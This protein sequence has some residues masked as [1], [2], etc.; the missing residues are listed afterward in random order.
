METTTP[1]SDGNFTKYLA[2]LLGGGIL[3]L[4]CLGASLGLFA[5]S[6]RLAAPPITKIEFLD[7]KLRFLRDHREIDPSLIV[8]GSSIAWR[9]FDGEPFAARLGQNRVLNGA[10]AYLKVHQTR[11]LT[12]FYMD[13]F[14]RLR[15]VVL[16]FGPTDFENCTS[17]QANLFDPE[18][19]S[20]YVFEHASPASFYMRYF[21]PAHYLLRASNYDERQ[22]PLL[23]DLFM[24][25][26]GSGPMQWTPEM[27]KG[28]R[29]GQQRLD[30][31]CI[32]SLLTLLEEIRARNIRPVVVF[33][34][35][36]PE[37]R[38]LYPESILQ[39]KQVVAQVTAEGGQ[40]GDVFDMINGNFQTSDFFDAIHL[41]WTAVQRFS[42][43]L[44]DL[45]LPLR[46]VTTSEPL[47]MEPQTSID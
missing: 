3:T 29:Y 10:T 42:K 4:A 23:G 44:A 43:Q 38:R 21:S 18:E 20:R 25:R 2:G 7:E 26:Y 19:G 1:A 31:A 34:P 17:T 41:Q 30:N 11:F 14:R 27:I 15:T 46:A 12:T 24:D 8:V 47:S 36:H 9:Q 40:N 22:V 5:W 13:H 16:M 28:L 39:L 6:G 37:F 35:V 45:V 32:A 33:A